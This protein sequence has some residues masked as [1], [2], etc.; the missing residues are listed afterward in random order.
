R[1]VSGGAGAAGGGGGGPGGGSGGG[2]AGRGSAVP[3]GLQNWAGRGVSPP[4]LG[5]RFWSRSPHSWP[6]ITPSAFSKRQLNPPIGSVYSSRLP[7]ARKIPAPS[8]SGSHL[9]GLGLKPLPSPPSQYNLL[10]G[11]RFT[12]KVFLQGRE[13]KT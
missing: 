1:S 10:R 13:E 12:F 11:E 5:H 3:Q 9:Q 6:K 2:G 8:P 4:P 7:W